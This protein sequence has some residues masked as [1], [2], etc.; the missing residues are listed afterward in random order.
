MAKA[1]KIFRRAWTKDDVRQLKVL[2]KAKVGVKKIVIATPKK[3]PTSVS[4]SEIKKAVQD[5][6][7]RPR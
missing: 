4:R 3:G 6:A 1:K 7:S 2:A 5:H